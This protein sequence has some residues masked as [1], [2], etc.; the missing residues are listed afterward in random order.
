MATLADKLRLFNPELPLEQARTIPSAWYT[1]PEIYAAECQSVF[2]GTWQAAARVEQLSQPGS[3][4]TTTIA[5]EPILILRDE[6]GHLRA[7]FNVCRHRAAVVVNEP[8][9]Q[10]SKLRCRYHGWTYDLTGALRGTPE[11]EGVADF[12]REELEL[13]ALAVDVWTPY[14]WVHT[15]R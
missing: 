7:F 15:A 9:G 6:Q 2:G 11:S 13:V 10:A 3:F 12:R 14:A 5:G 8:C 4:V 1:D